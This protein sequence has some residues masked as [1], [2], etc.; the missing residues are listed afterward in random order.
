MDQP[1]LREV[2]FR[3]QLIDISEE[4]IRSVQFGLTYK[5]PHSTTEYND[6]IEKM[7][8]AVSE[9]NVDLKTELL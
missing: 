5:L 7:R 8:W 9:K 2:L 4:T 6:K 3:G 1:R